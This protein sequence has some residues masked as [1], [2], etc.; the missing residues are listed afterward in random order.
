VK[1]FHRV[2]PHPIRHDVRKRRQSQFKRAFFA[3][4]TATARE[5]DQLFNAGENVPNGFHRGGR[6]VFG[7]VVADAFEIGGSFAASISF[8]SGLAAWGACP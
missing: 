3:P 6:V 4:F 2:F 1:D 5:C 7:N 8:L